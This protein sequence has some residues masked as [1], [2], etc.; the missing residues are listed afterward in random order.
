MEITSQVSHPNHRMATTRDSATDGP[1]DDY[2]V[3][4]DAVTHH[5]W[6]WYTYNYIYVYIFILIYI[7]LYIYSYIYIFIFIYTYNIYSFIYIY[8]HIYIYIYIYIF[9]Y[10]FIFMYV[11]IYTHIYI[12]LYSLYIYIHLYLHTYLHLYIYIYSFIHMNIHIY[13][14]CIYIYIHTYIY[15]YSFLHHSQLWHIIASKYNHT[16]VEMK[17]VL[18]PE[19]SSTCNSRYLR[20][21][22]KKHK[23]SR[24]VGFSLSDTL[25]LPRCFLHLKSQGDPPSIPSFLSLMVTLW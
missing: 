24:C 25:T 14:Y 6:Y 15:R 16:Q 3:L 22:L 19:E 13:I 18:A 4:S 21:V 5:T 8:T 20:Y 2:S 12:Y 10:V 11:Y 23:E 9:I 1:L 7:H 17:D